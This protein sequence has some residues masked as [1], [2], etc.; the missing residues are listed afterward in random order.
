VRNQVVVNKVILWMRRLLL[1]AILLGVLFW[2][3]F[4]YIPRT[5]VLLPTIA[6]AEPWTN[7]LFPV[8]ALVALLIFAA[9][10]LWLLWSVRHLRSS[11]A[12][13]PVR[14]R[15]SAEF[16]WTALPLLLTLGLAIA[17]YPL[18]RELLSR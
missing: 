4:S 15:R 5:W 8:L 2:L 9:I 7:Q 3:V 18:W 16:F 1:P 12:D 6:F 13:F 10:Q 14:M 11:P 17:G